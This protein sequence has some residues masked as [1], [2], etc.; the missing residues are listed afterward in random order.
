MNVR[1]RFN[2]DFRAANWYTD[3]LLINSYAVAMNLI[4]ASDD[5]NVHPICL[6]RIRTIFDLLEN[7]VFIKETNTKKIDQL[8]ECGLRVIAFPEEPIDQIVGIMLYEKLNAILE[9]RMRITDIDVCSDHGDNIWFMHSEHEKIALS[10]T[11]GWWNDEG[12]S[13]TTNKKTKNIN[14]IK[15]NKPLSWESFGLDWNDEV[16]A[17][18]AVI[19]NIKDE[20]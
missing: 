2:S 3:E 5:P 19:I 13:C 11:P 14:I 12:P 9:G 8:T 17:E 7:S 10:Y 16:P 1:L 6:G 4:T 20:K 18:P 15:L